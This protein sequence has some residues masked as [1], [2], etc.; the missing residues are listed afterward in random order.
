MRTRLIFKLKDVI[1]ADETQEDFTL[2][3]I[4][5]WKDILAQEMECD[6]EDIEVIQNKV[7]VELG[8][9]LDSTIDGFVF[10]KAIKFDPIQGVTLDIIE[11]S[12]EHLDAIL[13]GS[14]LDHIIFF[15]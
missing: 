5:A 7:E 4:A 6:I 8:E 10:Y 14:I 2:I 3:E 12:N 9:E 13:D 11:G 15:T 1:I